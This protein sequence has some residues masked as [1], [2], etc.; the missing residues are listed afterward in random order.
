MTGT[1]ASSGSRGNGD[2]RLLL[3]AIAASARTTGPRAGP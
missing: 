2:S 1:E 3:I